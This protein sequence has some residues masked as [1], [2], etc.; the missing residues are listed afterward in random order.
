MSEQL[1]RMYWL[2]GV[3]G[4]LWLHHLVLRELQELV[5]WVLWVQGR[6]RE[7][8]CHGLLDDLHDCLHHQLRGNLHRRLLRNMYA[9]RHVRGEG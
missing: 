8:V 6:M 1:L 4:V 3:R 7:G 9:F 2:P 5:L